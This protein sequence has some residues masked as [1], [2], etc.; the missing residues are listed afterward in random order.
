ME[1]RDLREERPRLG[2]TQYRAGCELAKRAERKKTKRVAS[3]PRE[4]GPGQT[5]T[6]FVE[7]RTAGKPTSRSLCR[8]SGGAA[9]FSVRRQLTFLLHEL[10][11]QAPFNAQRSGLAGQT[12]SH[13]KGSGLTKSQ[14]GCKL[15]RRAERKK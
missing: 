9:G 11:H 4:A 6:Q 5:K 12:F 2:L 15:A 14:T 1:A 10:R 13:N 3:R 8:A 7:Q